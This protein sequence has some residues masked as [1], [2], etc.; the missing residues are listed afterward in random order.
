M[1]RYPFSRPRCK[2]TL[3]ADAPSHKHRSPFCLVALGILLLA[4]L[5]LMGLCQEPS[6]LPPVTQPPPPTTEFREF[7]RSS[8]AERTIVILRFPSA[9]STPY[10]ENNFVEAE[11]I[12]PR[13]AS[14]PMPVVVVL[15]YWGATSLTVEE[16][17][18]RA[19]NEKGIAV[20]ILTLPYH[21]RRTPKGV[22]SGILVIKPDIPHLRETMTQ[23]VMDV[24]RLVDWLQK[25]SDFDASK[26]GLAGISLGAI[27]GSLAFAV[28]PRFSACALLLGGADLAHIIWNSPAT[29]ETRNKLRAMGFAEEKLREEL[30]T[31]EP[32]HYLKKDLS[33]K[34]LLVSAQYDDVIPKMAFERLREALGEPETVWV[35]AGHY[36]TILV[37][38]RLSRLV[39]D[40]FSARFSGKT[41]APPESL[42][43]PAIRV[44]LTYNPDYQL[45]LAIGADLWKAN[46]QGIG[47]ASGMLSP[48]GP[49]LFAGVPVGNRFNLGV[50]ATKRRVTFGILWSIIL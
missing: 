30:Q 40:F 23:A 50:T 20:A 47:F 13:E 33:E 10:P 39:A 16:R 31:I 15:H 41:Y 11:I 44:G 2:E 26:I 6:P 12:K 43:A 4:S 49:L 34:V 22:Q 35:S 8:D 1:P 29:I 7:P 14:L 48:Q 45:T 28:E 42:W 9:L 17:F 38:R 32:L 36:G 5:P 19:L 46:K 25:Q 37:E 18:A 27:I 24:K 3:P 21:L